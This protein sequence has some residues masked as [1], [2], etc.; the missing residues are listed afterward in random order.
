GLGISPNLK[1]KHMKNSKRKFCFFCVLLLF[2]ASVYTL[3]MLAT[4]EGAVPG[5]MSDKTDTVSR[6][7]RLI[8]DF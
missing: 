6:Q 4:V 8:A 7:R 5:P 1:V 3:A 2:F